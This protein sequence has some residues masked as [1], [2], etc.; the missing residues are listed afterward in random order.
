VKEKGVKAF[1][2][3]H[4]RGILHDDVRAANVLVGSDER[5]WI[6]DFEYSHTL[7]G[8]EN[9]DKLLTVEKMAVRD[10]LASIKLDDSRKHTVELFSKDPEAA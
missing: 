2:E 7:D 8:D 10:M 3:I 6:I 9:S 4:A 5:V 1:D